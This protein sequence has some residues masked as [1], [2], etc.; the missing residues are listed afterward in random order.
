[1]TCMCGA[2]ERREEGMRRCKH[3]IH[4]TTGHSFL[5]VLVKINIDARTTSRY[6]DDLVCRLR[7]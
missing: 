7:T 1:M 6:T 3:I 2:T 5:W 4:T